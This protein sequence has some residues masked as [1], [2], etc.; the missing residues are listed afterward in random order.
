MGLLPEVLEEAGRQT[1]AGAGLAAEYGGA[2]DVAPSGQRG[3]ARSSAVGAP[4]AWP[5]S[6]CRS[7]RASSG[8]AP[9]SRRKSFLPGMAAGEIMWGEGYTEPDS[10]SDLASLRTRAEPDGDEWVINGQKT[11]CTAGHHCN[12]IIIAAR[13]DPD[14]AK[15]H[16]GISYFLSPMDAPGLELRPCTTSPTAARTTCSSTICG[17]P[18]T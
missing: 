17:S 8:W 3:P 9:T 6:G 18:R 15:R 12:W 5:G 13:T 4:A 7:G 14:Y 10:G 2:G 1:L 11:F 16:R